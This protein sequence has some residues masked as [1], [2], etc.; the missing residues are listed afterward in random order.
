MLSN[1]RWR[2]VIPQISLILLITLLLAF[3][4]SHLQHVTCVSNL[5]D[6][7][8]GEARLLAQALVE[9]MTHPQMDASLGVLAARYADTL[10]AGVTVLAAD[11]AVLGDSDEGISTS[12]NLMYSPEVR[13]ALVDGVGSST[14]FSRAFDYNTV[15]VAVPVRSDTGIVGIVRVYSS[16]E[17]MD[18]SAN[19]VRW[20]LVGLALVAST[21]AAPLTILLAERSA[22]SLSELTAVAQRIAEGDLHAHL[23]TADQDELMQLTRALNSIADRLRENVATLDDEATRMT[24]VLNNMADGVLIT[25]AQGNV[26]LMNPAATRLLQIDQAEALG[27]SFAQ[28]ARDY[29]LI[30]LWQR[31]RDQAKEQ[32]ENI[33]LGLAHLFLRAVLTPLT[34][35]P[36]PS[37]L[38]I[39]QDLSEIRRLELARRDFLANISHE[40]RTPLAS[41][42]ALVDTLRDGAL[43]DPPAAQRFLDSM[44]TEVDGL[45]QT[46][47][48]SLELSRV[49]SGR[50]ALYLV[51]TEVS[52]IVMPVVDRLR[53]QADRAHLDLEVTVPSDPLTVLADA[54]RGPQALT[55]LLHNAIKFTPPG[56]SVTVS[57]ELVGEEVVFSVRDTG[58]GIAAEDLTRIFERFYKADR[59]RSGGG[60]GLGLAIAKHIVQGHGG[61]IWAESTEGRG[62]SFFFTLPVVN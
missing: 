51:P 62:S 38:V 11:G 16:L 40:L 6:R 25:D 32:S 58:V 2:V 27:H 49:E 46:V 60:T 1:I 20:Q 13:E 57:A 14:R 24:A 35:A 45:A 53:P 56:G 48:E 5:G 50:G 28:V 54:Q 52:R 17:P 4:L 8:Q 36:D 31:C 15:Y 22:G 23:L 59:A 26:R 41:L 19:R 21:A 18:S 33:E 12:G 10:G 30:E 44:E 39:L 42:K 9:P 3:Y 61:R 34:D 37:C 43:E 29:Q 55:N 47:Q 7:L